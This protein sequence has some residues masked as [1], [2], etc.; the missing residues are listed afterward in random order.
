M[1]V[2]VG[3]PKVMTP[4]RF[5]RLT[6][7]IE[8]GEVVQEKVISSATYLKG[9]NYRHKQLCLSALLQRGDFPRNL[10]ITEKK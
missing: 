9:L 1:V 10:K 6:E 7:I 5:I 4:Y 3:P 8:A 2:L